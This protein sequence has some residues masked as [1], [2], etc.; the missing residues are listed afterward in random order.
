M[1]RYRARLKRCAIIAP[2]EVDGPIIDLLVRTNWLLDRDAT[3]K[4][5]IAD[6]IK[7]VLADATLGVALPAAR[8]PLGCANFSEGSKRPMNG[9]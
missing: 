2:V 6:A 7:R 8:L 9:L 4:L 5:A 1:Q 3:D